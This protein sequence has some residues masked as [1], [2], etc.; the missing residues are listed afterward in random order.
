[1]SE[2]RIQSLLYIFLLNPPAAWA[3]SLQLKRMRQLLDTPAVR[4]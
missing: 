3:L 4:K 2:S 1:M